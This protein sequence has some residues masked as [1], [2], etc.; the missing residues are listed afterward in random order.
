MAPAMNSRP[1]SSRFASGKPRNRADFDQAV[2]SRI[3]SPNLKRSSGVSI[4]ATVGQREPQCKQESE[5]HC[6]TCADYAYNVRSVLTLGE[7]RYTVGKVSA[8]LR[9]TRREAHRG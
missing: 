3:R 1:I 9:G 8:P 4:L 5:A 7:G 6:V 2:R